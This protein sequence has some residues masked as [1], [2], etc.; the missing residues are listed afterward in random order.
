MKQVFSLIQSAQLTLF[1]AKGTGFGAVLL[2]AL[3]VI[4]TFRVF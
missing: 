4:V 3:M 2:F 1:L